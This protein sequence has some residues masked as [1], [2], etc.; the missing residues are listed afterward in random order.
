MDM[1]QPQE[2]DS[3]SQVGKQNI[4]HMTEASCHICK[5]FNAVMRF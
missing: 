2:Q 4:S 3:R 1:Q 5:M